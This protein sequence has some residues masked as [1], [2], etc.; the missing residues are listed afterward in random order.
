MDM[1][2]D[3]TFRS[4]DEWRRWLVANAYVK[5][6]S[7]I[8][9][10]AEHCSKQGALSDFHASRSE[11]IVRSE[12]YRE[13]VLAFGLNPRQRVVL[14]IL[15]Q[16]YS[17]Q[18][19]DTLR[20]HLHEAITRLALTIKGHFPYTI[21]SEYLPD[22]EHKA[23]RFPIPH[24]D[25]CHS[26]LPAK[27]FDLIISLEVLEHVPSIDAAL[28]DMQRILKVEGRLLATF[29]FRYM[30]ASSLKRATLDGNG[31]VVHLLDPEYHGNPVDREKGSLVFE[32]PGWDIVE[33]AKQ[34]GFSDAGFRFVGSKA[35]GIFSKDL[36]GIFVFFAIN[37]CV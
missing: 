31:D 27:S 23:Q 7:V 28:V 22:D 21:A 6:P 5:D 30:S 1:E 3:Q 11:V 16:L 25:I 20:V 26:S 4:L 34:I 29:P 10:W 33:K 32:I 18:A 13:H 24:V 2:I 15:S 36:T 17:K 12:N 37:Y 8:A 35:R 14:D 9:G 19:R